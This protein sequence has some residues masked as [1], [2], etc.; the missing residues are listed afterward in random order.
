[1]MHGCTR[2]AYYLLFLEVAFFLALKEGA[3]RSWKQ[4]L[5]Q[6]K[7]REQQVVTLLSS[8]YKMETFTCNFVHVTLINSSLVE[9][10]CPL[11]TLGDMNDAS[12]PV[13]R[14]GSWVNYIFII[15][16]LIGC[17]AMNSFGK[18]FTVFYIKQSAPERPLNDMIL[19]DQVCIF[20][21]LPLSN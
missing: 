10:D 15:L 12:I 7:K 11:V 8:S 14:M 16:L 13:L 6:L 9:T 4:C 19:I 3:Q 1:M 21:Y 5:T 2:C 17:V 18:A 20:V